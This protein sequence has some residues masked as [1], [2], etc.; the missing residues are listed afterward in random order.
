LNAHPSPGTALITGAS[1]GLGESFARRLAKQGNN[2]I[3]VA[4]REDRLRALADALHKEH[5]IQAEVLSAD[6]SDD[7]G[8]K[9]VEELIRSRTDLTLLVNNAG[10]G[11]GGRFDRVDI[12]KQA[13]MIH[14]HIVAT[15]RLTRAALPSMVERKK[16]AIINVASVA[17]FAIAPRSA[18]Y[19][20][21][22]AWEVAFSRAL[23]QDLRGTGIRVQV[24]CPGFT[25]TEF[26]DAADMKDFKR[27]SIPKFMWMSADDV[28]AVS[29]NALKRK[30]VVI[31]PGFGNKLLAAAARLP[32][33][34]A[35]SGFIFRKHR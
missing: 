24:L 2:L 16:G 29:L 15:A 12:E 31:I 21:T 27:S 13:A 6:L 5:H 1:S 3:L 30:K 26:H 8:I 19:G 18:M 10:F 7:A 17:A 14:V 32:F 25:I 33:A 4:R 23:A 34:A 11:A 28:V 20:S 22:K 35:F 9:R